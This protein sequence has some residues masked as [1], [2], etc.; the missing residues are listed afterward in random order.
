MYDQIVAVCCELEPLRI[1]ASFVSTAKQ[2]RGV[3]LVCLLFDLEMIMPN[4]ENKKRRQGENFCVDWKR[5]VEMRR[6]GL[7]VLWRKFDAK[8][9]DQKGFMASSKI[10]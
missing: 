7:G 3:Y 10:E 6:F 4:C 2:K 8:I 9:V 5:L 1:F